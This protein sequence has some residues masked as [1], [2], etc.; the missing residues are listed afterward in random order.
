[1]SAVVENKPVARGGLA[2]KLAFYNG[3]QVGHQHDPRDDPSR[4]DHPGSRAGDMQP[5]RRRPPHDLRGLRRREIH[6]HQGQDGPQFLQG[7]QAA[8]RGPQRGG[9]R[10]VAQ[11]DRQ[12]PRRLRRE[13][14]RGLQPAPELPPAGRR[15]DGVSHAADARRAGGR[16][17]D[18]RAG[19]RRAAHQHQVRRAL[20]GGDGR[21]HR[22]ALRDARHRAAPAPAAV[23]AGQGQVRRAD[24]ERRDLGGG[25][26]TRDAIGAPQESR[27]RNGAD[28]RVPGEA[29]RDRRGPGRLFRRSVRAVQGRS[30]E[31]LRPAQEPEPGIPGKQRLGAHRRH[32]GRHGGADDRPGE[33]ARLAGRQQRLSEGQGQL[34]GL[35]QSRV[36]HG[37]GPAVRRDDERHGPR[38]DRRPAVRHAGRRRRRS[39][40]G[41]EVRGRRQRGRQARQQGHRR[42][43]PAGGIGHPHRALSGP[44]QDRD[45]LSQGRAAAALHL[46]APQLPQR[47]RGA[48][49]DHVRPRHLRA[50]QAPGWQDQVQEVRPARHRA[51]RRHRA[52]AG[53][54]GRHRDAHPRRR[55][56]HPARQARPVQAQPGDVQGDGVE[57][58]W[59]VLRVRADRIGQDHD[60][61]FG[62]GLPQ[63]AGHE[64][65]D[66]RGSGGNHAARAAPGAG[67]SEGGADVRRGDAG[68]PALRSRHHHGR[69]DAGPGNRGDG[70]RGVADRPSRAGD[71]AHEQ[72]AGVHRA[73]PRH[74]HG[75]VQFRRRAA[76]SPGAAAGPAP[77]RELQAGSPS[78]PTPSSRPCWTSTRSS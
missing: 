8:G 61:A 1:M 74:G 6:R 72:R 22:A 31:A 36:R 21:R 12:H 30:R 68:V 13:G 32:Q 7:L 65:L 51:A 45:P 62:A 64:D 50:A 16:S 47:D 41:H 63:Q 37:A 11:A 60:A 48:H 40:G 42:R 35:L 43:V 5:L 52:V 38:I 26:G 58:V 56:A 10:R 18:R 67:Q 71:A 20:S 25:A 3:L 49:Q 23:R 70:H 66:G 69:R 2:D 15:Q 9:L 33:A 4:R 28:R 77:V 29:E 19:R 73:A 39:R 78:R 17:A 75:S 14:A 46:R 34:P 24:R 54:H 44:G 59:P 76:G 53:R 27:R 57:A 55:R